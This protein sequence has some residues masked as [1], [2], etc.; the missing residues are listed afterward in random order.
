MEDGIIKAAI[1][2]TKG[3]LIQVKAKIFIDSTGDGD[4]A[5]LSGVP[6]EVGGQDFAGLNMSTTQGSRWSGADLIRYQQAEDKWKAEQKEKGIENPLPLVY[7]LEEEA[8]KRG[9]M[10][11]HVCNR[12]SGFSVYF[13]PI[14]RMIMRSSLHFH[15][16]AI[17][18]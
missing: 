17:L 11:R 13:C 8:I 7:V 4:V 18:P 14:H 3:G 15:F 9:E 1:F 10:A 16:T 12:V 2:Y 6:Y 5:A